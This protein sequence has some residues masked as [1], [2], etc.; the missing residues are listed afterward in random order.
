MVMGSSG[1]AKAK[2]ADA[3]V[4]MRWQGAPRLDLSQS[5]LLAVRMTKLP[6][7]RRSRPVGMTFVT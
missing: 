1:V 4:N 3:H 6:G 2:L 5:S 7:V